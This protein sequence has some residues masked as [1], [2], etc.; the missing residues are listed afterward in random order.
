M[1]R[2][3]TQT[4]Y[5]AR[6]AVLFQRQLAD[7]VKAP[8]AE[9]KQNQNNYF[10]ALEGSNS[11]TNGLVAT[12]IGWLLGGCYGYGSQ[13]AARRIIDSPR[14]NQ[15]AALSCII[16]AIEWGCSALSAREAWR[17]LPTQRQ[18][19]VNAEIQAEIDDYLKEKESEQ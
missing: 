17:K 19:A 3:P 1:T 10:E 2:T 18:Q 11:D 9:R 15:V 7:T 13:Q 5:E 8:L 14:M 4:E 12:R 6:E 16:A